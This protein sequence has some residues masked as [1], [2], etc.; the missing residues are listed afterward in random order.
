M[1]LE[2]TKPQ[3]INLRN[4]QSKG[5]VD[6]LLKIW[7]PEILKPKFEVGKWYIS[8][9]DCLFNYRDGYGCYGFL[10]YK[11]NIGSWHWDQNTELPIEDASN[12]VVTEWLK[13][14]A[15]KRYPDGIMVNFLNGKNELSEIQSKKYVP[16]IAGSSFIYGGGVVMKDG[17][18]A[19]TETELANKY[20][21]ILDHEVL[22]KKE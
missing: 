12:T 2:I 15:M 18:W 1:K 9:N 7:Y 3:I 14:E 13:I 19:E 6:N 16:I 5:E 8:G 4:A 22:E 20:L 17:I 11:W 10:N 21:K